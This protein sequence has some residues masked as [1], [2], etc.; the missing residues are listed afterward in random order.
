[1]KTSLEIDDRLYNAAR[2]RAAQERTTV[3]ALIE[4]GLAQVLGLGPGQ[5]RSDAPS[6]RRDHDDLAALCGQVSSLP[7]LATGTTDGLLGYDEGG[8]FA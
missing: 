7:L 3:R 8:S 2:I 4:Q 6:A 1:M 5:P